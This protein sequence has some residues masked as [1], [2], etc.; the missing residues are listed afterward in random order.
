MN[1]YGATLRPTV[2]VAVHRAGWQLDWT[3]YGG[4]DA[5]SEVCQRTSESAQCIR[6]QYPKETS[7]GCLLRRLTPSTW[8]R[9]Q[10]RHLALVTLGIQFLQT[11]LYPDSTSTPTIFTLALCMQQT[12]GRRKLHYI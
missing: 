10:Q 11:Y 7:A 12:A 5:E 3:L 6:I 4:S 8:T 9:H 2:F 1:V